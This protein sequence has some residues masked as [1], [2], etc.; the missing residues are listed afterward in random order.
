M[1]KQT[2]AWMASICIFE[3]WMTLCCVFLSVWR[4]EQDENYFQSILQINS[5]LISDEQGQ[6]DLCFSISRSS[7]YNSSSVL[8]G[9]WAVARSSVAAL[10]PLQLFK[11]QCQQWH[12]RVSGLR[13][14]WGFADLLQTVIQLYSCFIES[15]CHFWPRPQL[16]AKPFFFWTLA[17]CPPSPSCYSMTSD[18]AAGCSLPVSCWLW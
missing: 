7:C 18:L 9:C 17:F 13:P 2:L 16:K 12:C 15:H 11:P 8:C 3:L 5:N 10:Q 14:H 1:W 6:V 4:R